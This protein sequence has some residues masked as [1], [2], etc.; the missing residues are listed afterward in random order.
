MINTSDL[1]IENEILPL[2]DF[3]F[4]LHSGNAVRDLI[5]KAL[6]TKEEILQRQLVLKG[7]IANQE[8][9]KDYSFSRFNLAEI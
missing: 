6:R 2:F 5:T 9:L 7:F 8:I 4:N 1:N 3:T